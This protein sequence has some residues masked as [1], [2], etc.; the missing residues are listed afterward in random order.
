MEGLPTEGKEGW[1]GGGGE[2]FS[3]QRCNRSDGESK[4]EQTRE[5]M[6][7]YTNTPLGRWKWL[8][9]EREVRLTP[10]GLP[11]MQVTLCLDVFFWTFETSRLPDLLCKHWFT[12]SVWNFCCSGADVPPG[13]T[14]LVVTSEEKRLF[15]QARISC[16]KN[17]FNH[18]LLEDRLKS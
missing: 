17:E 10:V 12:S 2:N 4:R 11:T 5:C 1:G 9:L 6:L 8:A 14:Y 15:S 18:T 13:E 3:T 7:F 16:E